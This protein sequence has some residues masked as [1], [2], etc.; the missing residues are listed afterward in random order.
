MKKGWADALKVRLLHLSS[1]PPLE[2]L[3]AALVDQLRLSSPLPP[4]AFWARR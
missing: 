2:K 3:I 1:L 4:V